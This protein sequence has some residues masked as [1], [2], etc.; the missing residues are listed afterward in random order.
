MCNV[1]L[2]ASSLFYMKIAIKKRYLLL[3]YSDEVFGKIVDTLK[4]FST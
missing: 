3:M 2:N 1:I 4:K